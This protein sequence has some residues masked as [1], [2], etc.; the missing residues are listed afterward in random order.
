MNKQMMWIWV[1]VA[2]VV[3]AAAGFYFERSR[4]TAKMESY[5]MEVQKQ[6]DDAKMK[7]DQLMK[8]QSME[9]KKMQTTPEPSGMMQK[10]AA[11]TGAMMKK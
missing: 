11:P 3:G 4:A 6:M 9:D 5:K 10:G 1:T 2:L 7:T 8:D